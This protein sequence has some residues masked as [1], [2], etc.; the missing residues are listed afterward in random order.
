MLDIVADHSGTGISVAAVA[1]VFDVS[2]EHSYGNVA[3]EGGTVGVGD[4][5]LVDLHQE[6][7]QRPIIH[8]PPA[9]YPNVWT[10]YT[11]AAA[12]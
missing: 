9:S 8:P 2:A 1:A 12:S 4:D 7:W 3:P 11:D 5:G 6:L 10:I